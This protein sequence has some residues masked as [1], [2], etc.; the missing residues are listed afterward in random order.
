MTRLIQVVALVVAGVV[1]LIAGELTWHWAMAA[2]GGLELSTRFTASGAGVEARVLQRDFTKRVAS[3]GETPRSVQCRPDL[4]A[5]VGAVSRC[6]ASFKASGFPD[7]GDRALPARSGWLADNAEYLVT[8]VE[9]KAVSVDITPGLRVD[10]LESALA[11]MLHTA[12]YLDCPRTGLR[13]R[14]GETVR[15]QGTYGYPEGPCI[16][17]VSPGRCTLTVAVDRVDGMSLD[18]RIAHVEPP[19]GR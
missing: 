17:D 19:T 15:C 12:T 2:T 6:D 18:L 16:G 13:A 8:K 11:Q 7:S 3:V 9:G 5:R 10:H 14:F 1:G 4:V